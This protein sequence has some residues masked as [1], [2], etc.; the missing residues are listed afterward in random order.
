MSIHYSLNNFI[1]LMNYL[2]NAKP[3]PSI[4]KYKVDMQGNVYD[5]N[6]IKIKQFN[7]NGYKQVLLFDSNHNRIIKGV[8]QLVA[9]TFIPDFYDGCIVHHIDENKQNNDVNNLEIMSK[10]A[11]SRLHANPMN[12]IIYTR[13]NGPINKGQKMSKEFREAC[14]RAAIKRHK[15]NP[16]GFKGNQFVNAD[17]IPKLK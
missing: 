13:Q 7:S 3:I 15:E 1:D 6:G 14:R 16:S 11:H 9:E 2:Y 4:S 12:L 8:H 5:D 10:S 17:K